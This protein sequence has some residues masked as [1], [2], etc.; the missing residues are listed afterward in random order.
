MAQI[1]V[2]KTGH[3]SWDRKQE[4]L[5][6]ELTE[7]IL[8]MTAEYLSNASPLTALEAERNKAKREALLEA[9]S[10]FDGQLG[11]NFVAADGY[12]SALDIASELRAMADEIGD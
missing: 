5:Y 9:A 10:K 11:Y 4:E 7:A 1:S 2:T 6:K 12:S 3:I 8:P